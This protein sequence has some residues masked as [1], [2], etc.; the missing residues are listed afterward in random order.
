MAPAE[1][2]A[3][4]LT[5]AEVRDAAVVGTPDADA[6]ELP[7]AFVV[8][9]PGAVATPTEIADF[10]AGRCSLVV[11][12]RWWSVVVEWNL[13]WLSKGRLE[14]QRHPVCWQSAGIS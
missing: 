6:G 4:L 11:G 9:Q 5:H 1:L 2:E 13:L 3:V 12:A 10:V 8:L 7:T 14:I